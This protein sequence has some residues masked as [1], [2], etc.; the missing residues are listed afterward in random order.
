M[1]KRREAR[2]RALEILYQQEITGQPL[3]EIIETYKEQGQVLN[4]FTEKIIFGVENNIREIDKQIAYAS[5][6]WTLDRMPAIDKN[7]LRISTYE[8]LKE[9]EIPISVSINEAIEIAKDYGTPDSAKFINGV[10]GAISAEIEKNG[11]KA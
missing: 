11:R 4:E 6:R 2:I 7:I 3:E 9:K 1:K 8:I 5:D 10:L